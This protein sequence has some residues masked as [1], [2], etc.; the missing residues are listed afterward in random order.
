MESSSQQPAS[1]RHAHVLKGKADS[2]DTF[3]DTADDIVMI[4]NRRSSITTVPAATKKA[5]KPERSDR[6]KQSKA[7]NNS[8]DHGKLE[9][10]DMEKIE[11]KNPMRYSLEPKGFATKRNSADVRLADKRTAANTL[12]STELKYLLP[13]L[14]TGPPHC[15]LNLTSC[16]PPAGAMVSSASSAHSAGTKPK[17][18]S[19]KPTRRSDPN[20]DKKWKDIR[21]K[22]LY[23]GSKCVS[24][25]KSK[26]YEQMMNEKANPVLSSSKQ[27]HPPAHHQQSA[28]A[29]SHSLS[30]LTLELPKAKKVKQE[31]QMTGGVKHLPK[32]LTATASTPKPKALPKK[33]KQNQPASSQQKNGGGR[34][35]NNKGKTKGK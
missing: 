17:P 9:I 28:P 30:S 20:N 8:F 7:I 18:G 3:G 1:Q 25:E 34:S 35:S 12:A 32:P 2:E 5:T 13:P 22:R 6:G 29:L 14:P 27:M 26:K 31:K 24:V 16:L 33:K 11:T 21:N 23:G 4:Q 10:L 19:K 15:T